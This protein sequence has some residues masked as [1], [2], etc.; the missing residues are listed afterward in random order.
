VI[1]IVIIALCVAAIA[2]FDPPLVM[3][4]LLLAVAGVANGFLAPPRDMIIRALAPPSEIGKV[5]GFVSS[6]FA[7]AGIIAPVLYGW[8]LDHSDARNVFWIASGVALLT[9]VTVLF[10]GREGRR[11][12]KPA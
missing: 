9:V 6:G 1:C 4:G 11:I 3:I 2:S 8:I 5:F 7:F 10:T 12:E